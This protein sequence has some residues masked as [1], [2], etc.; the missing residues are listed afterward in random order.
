MEAPL[1]SI[2]MSPSSSPLTKNWSRSPSLSKN[3]PSLKSGKI[4]KHSS[5]PSSLPSRSRSQ[6]TRP[7]SLL[8]KSSHSSLS[9]SLSKSQ[10]T[11]PSLKSSQLS[12]PSSL[13]SRSRSQKTKPSLLSKSPTKGPA[14]I[15]LVTFW[16]QPVLAV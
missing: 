9:P 15:T 16:A 6:K 5:S 8:L 2:S 7:S 1:S 3:P 4:T 13:P 12:S 14:S 11:K 10:M